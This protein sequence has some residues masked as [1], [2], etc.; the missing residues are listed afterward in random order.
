MVDQHVHGWPRT[1]YSRN[2]EKECDI[3]SE[4]DP[5]WVQGDLSPSTLTKP[6]DT[7]GAPLQFFLS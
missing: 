4:A 2:G 3:W 7:P 1:V 5:M 6:I